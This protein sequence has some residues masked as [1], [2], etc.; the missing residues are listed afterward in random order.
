MTLTIRLKVGL[1]LALQHYPTLGKISLHGRTPFQIVRQICHSVFFAGIEIVED[2]ARE[3]PQTVRSS[4][5]PCHEPGP[6][7]NATEDRVLYAELAVSRLHFE[8][9]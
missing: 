3:C 9:V 5:D 8:R 7:T 2:L 4:L 1:Q 6:T